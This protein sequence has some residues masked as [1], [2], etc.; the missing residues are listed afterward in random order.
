MHWCAPSVIGSILVVHQVGYLGHVRRM[1]RGKPPRS[2]L[3]VLVARSL[4]D[5]E[6]VTITSV[7]SRNLFHNGYFY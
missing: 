6:L 1:S 4:S 3:P 2:L 5:H 7:L